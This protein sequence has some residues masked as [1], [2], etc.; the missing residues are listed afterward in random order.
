MRFRC[1]LLL[2][3]L[4]VVL[5]VSGSAPPA[6]SG[7]PADEIVKRSVIA[8][9][10]DWEAAP[11]YTCTEKDV[12]LKSGKKTSKT[13][14][15]LMIDGWPYQK[16]VAENGEPLSQSRAEAEERRLE[17]ERAHRE[18]EPPAQR[19]RE[20]AAYLL[21]RSQDH[22]LMQQMIKAFNFKLLGQE[23]VNGRRC[24]VLEGTPRPDYRPVNRDTQ[25]LKGMR[26]TLWVDT[27]SYQ[28][29]KVHAEVFR[30]VAFGLFV[31]H[32]EPGTE[33]TLEQG[34]V[35]D[36]IWLPTRFAQTVN[37]NILFLWHHTSSELDT[38]WA[39][40]RSAITE[41]ARRGPHLVRR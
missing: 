19:K 41:T 1:Q 37:A 7:P 16:L 40:R 25:V 17:C 23:V 27:N 28:W 2:I 15:D 39:Y 5:P 9:D 6:A 13:Y 36:G 14:E 11:H 18:E 10:R 4:A 33:I 26:G 34:P 31:A 12:I 22:E 32:V 38:Y 3:I 21:E 8:S 30:P 29:V 35:G 24:Y 20:V